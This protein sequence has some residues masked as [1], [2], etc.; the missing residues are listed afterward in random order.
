MIRLLTLLAQIEY[1]N[2]LVV[3]DDPEDHLRVNIKCSA[4]LDE[5]DHVEPTFP[6]FVFGDE[7]LRAA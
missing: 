6:A 3:V 2:K 7:G 1:F 4:D 5:L